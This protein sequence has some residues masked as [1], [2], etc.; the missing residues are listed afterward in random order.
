MFSDVSDSHTSNFL[1]LLMRYAFCLTVSA[2]NLIDDSVVS[3]QDTLF[4]S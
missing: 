4:G 1:L 3:L 2:N